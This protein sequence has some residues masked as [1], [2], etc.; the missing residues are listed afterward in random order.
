[1]KSTRLARAAAAVEW[2]ASE[3]GLAHGIDIFKDVQQRS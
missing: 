1:M 2:V 3:N